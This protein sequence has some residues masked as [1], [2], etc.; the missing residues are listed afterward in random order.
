MAGLTPLSQL[1]A[2]YPDDAPQYGTDLLAADPDDLSEVA[3]SLQRHIATAARSFGELD[4]NGPRA[5]KQRLMEGHIQP[6]RRKWVALGL[7]ASRKRVMVPNPTHGGTKALRWVSRRVPD[8]ETLATRAPL[9]QGGCYILFYGGD[10]DILSV[11]DGQGGGVAEDIAALSAATPL[12]DVVFWR[13]QK[14]HPPA[15]YSMTT[16]CGEVGEETVEFPDPDALAVALGKAGTV[17]SEPA[18]E[19]DS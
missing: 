13:S 15:M 1:I 9:P 12:A 11:K 14:G 7:D 17:V 5:V 16:G 8:A 6:L 2:G 4:F 19:G 10:P 18:Q 3:R